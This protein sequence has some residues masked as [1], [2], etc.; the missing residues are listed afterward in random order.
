MRQLAS[1][2][3]PTALKILEGSFGLNPTFLWLIGK[4]RLN[5]K[6][7][8]CLCTYCIK[9]SLLKQAGYISSDGHGIA[10]ISDK[11]SK[12]PF[13]KALALQLSLVH[14]C[15][16]WH[17]IHK[18]M[19][20]EMLMRRILSKAEGLHFMILAVVKGPFGNSTAGE[21]KAA[22]FEMSRMK[23]LPVYSETTMARNRTVY[24]RYGFRVYTHR[25]LPGAD[26]TIW[27][28]KR[29]ND[30]AQFGNK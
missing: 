22:V 4:K 24:E 15:I 14:N 3:L 5:T 12:A 18:V 19:Q 8:R 11:A 20:R 6:R 29:D 26:F 25:T 16:G 10:I 7:M 21:L 23:G 30:S 27:F 28:M 1:G 2:D 17:R 13:L 9:M